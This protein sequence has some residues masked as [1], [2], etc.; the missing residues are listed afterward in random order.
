MT[1]QDFISRGHFINDKL[2]FPCIR[3]TA[4]HRVVDVTDRAP[5]YF[6]Y[7]FMVVPDDFPWTWDTMVDLEIKRFVSL[8]ILD[9]FRE[10]V[11]V[12]FRSWYSEQKR[13]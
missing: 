3:Y 13:F 5:W 6:E 7:T 8:D 10:K 1:N 12:F 2:W 4:F 11:D 9:K